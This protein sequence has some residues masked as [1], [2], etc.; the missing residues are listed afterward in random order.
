MKYQRFHVQQQKLIIHP[1]VRNLTEIQFFHPFLEH[2]QYLLIYQEITQIIVNQI[3][4]N[5]VKKFPI[6][7]KVIYYHLFFNNNRYF[8]IINTNFD[9]CISTKNI[10]LKK[11][12]FFS[13]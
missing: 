11:I 13:F 8:K 7:T 5:Y 6:L 3:N 4:Q 10:Y 2:Y 12:N 1:Y 9:C